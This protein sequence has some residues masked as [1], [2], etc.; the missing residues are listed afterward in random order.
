MSNI[1]DAAYNREYDTCT[2]YVM[3]MILCCLIVNIE[4]ICCFVLVNN[5][6]LWVICVC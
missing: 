6:T 1:R 4:Y 5:Q 3:G 2:D